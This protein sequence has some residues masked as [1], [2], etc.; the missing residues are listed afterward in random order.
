MVCSGL[1]WD[2]DWDRWRGLVNAALNLRITLH[3]GNL[4]SRGLFSFSRTLL[5]YSM[6]D[7]ASVDLLNRLLSL[8]ANNRQRPYE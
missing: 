6:H 4:T 2:W 8:P 7:V 3:A 5:Q 1:T